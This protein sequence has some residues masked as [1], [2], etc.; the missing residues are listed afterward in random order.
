MLELIE[1][2]QIAPAPTHMG[3]SILL[4]N[5]SFHNID[6]QSVKFAKTLQVLIRGNDLDQPF[7]CDNKFIMV[8]SGPAT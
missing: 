3:P 5:L 1:Y 7:A 8:H 2:I 6:N 4:Q